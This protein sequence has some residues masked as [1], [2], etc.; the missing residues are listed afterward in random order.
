[1]RYPNIILIKH[2]IL[3]LQKK[4]KERKD[5]SGSAYNWNTLFL[6]QDTV[7]EVMAE[8]LGV[9]KGELLSTV[10]EKGLTDPHAGT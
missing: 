5:A 2:H 3:T 7:A 4:E 9:S 8:E 6:R 10:G 1:M